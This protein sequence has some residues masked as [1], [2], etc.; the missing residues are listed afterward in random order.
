MTLKSVYVALCVIGT[1]APLAFFVPFLRDHGVDPALFVD[2][3]FATPVSG[4]F[5]MDVV[6]SSVVLWVFVF[7]EGRRLGI[8]H[9]WAPI[10]ANL[11]IGVSLGL[12][13]FLYLRE[14]RSL[15]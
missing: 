15:R 2:Q 8:K 6:V 9:R 3:L 4:F 5:G 13:L 10:V 14:T 12:P 1:V 11:T 7:A